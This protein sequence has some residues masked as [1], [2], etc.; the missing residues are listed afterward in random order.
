MTEPFSP[1]PAA[2]T[3]AAA[4]NPFAVRDFRLLWAGEAVSALG[5]QFALIAL[6]W[7][8]LVLTGS[9]LALG[10]AMAL[11]AIPRALLM[12][13]GGV[14]VDRFSPR[15]VMLGSNAVRLGAVSALGAVVLAGRA[16]LW[17]L[18]AFALVFGVADAFFFPAQTAIVPELVSDEQLPRANGTVQG[19]AQVSVLVGPVAAGVVIAALGGT[20]TGAMVTGIGAALLFD[21]ATFVVSLATL[22]LIRPRAHVAQAHDSLLE[23]IR[24]AFQFVW[25]SRGMR[26]MVLVSLAAN[27]LIVGPFEVGMPFI[28]YSRLPEGAAAFGIV[29][30]AFGGGSL[31]GLLLGSV[32]PA[33]SARRFG[34]VVILPMALAGL[35]MAGLSAATTTLVAAALTAVAGIALGYTNLLSITWIQ[36]RIPQALMGR[37]MSLLITGSVGLVP[38]SM[39]VSGFAVQLNVDLTLLAAGIGMAIVALAAVSSAAVRDIGLEPFAEEPGSAPAAS[40][41]G[42]SA[43]GAPA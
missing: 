18:Y 31:V 43:E 17:M 22:L 33:P 38:V 20:A 4:R 16:E 1:A 39:F 26:A 24:E 19:T 2:A 11:M 42:T 13:V 10:G 28:A 35:S 40:S 3:Q 14:S 30:A 41:T 29:T 15:R 9:A 12:L 8:A 36:R 37:V 27:F 7:L 32:L 25:A 23:S 34:A 21:A 6:P 5:D